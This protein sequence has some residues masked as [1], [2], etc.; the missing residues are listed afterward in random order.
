MII[1][2]FLHIFSFLFFSFFLKKKKW[3]CRQDYD[4]SHFSSGN[5]S[6]LQFAAYDSIEEALEATREEREARERE[7]AERQAYLQT[8]EGQAQQRRNAKKARRRRTKK[9]FKK[10]AVY[11]VGML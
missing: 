8:P 7:E 3:L 2:L 6:G 9:R 10:A 1:N 11:T 4:G 5:C